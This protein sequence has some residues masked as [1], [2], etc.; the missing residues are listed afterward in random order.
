VDLPE[1]SKPMKQIIAGF[2]ALRSLLY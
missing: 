1:P 2:I